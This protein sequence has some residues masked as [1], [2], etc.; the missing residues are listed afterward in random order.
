MCTEFQGQTSKGWVYFAFFFMLFYVEMFYCF[1][2]IKKLVRNRLKFYWDL[3]LI[4]RAQ[5]YTHLK[6]NT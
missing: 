6:W 4:R 2:D 1:C 5:T 3:E